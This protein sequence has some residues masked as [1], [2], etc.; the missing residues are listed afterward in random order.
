MK[1]NFNSAVV[2][3]LWQ[4]VSSKQFDPDDPETK[5][6]MMLLKSQIQDRYS[7]SMFFPTLFK[8]L[9]MREVDRKLQ[10]LKSKMKDIIEDHKL[11]IDYQNPRDFIDVYLGHMRENAGSSFN[12]EQ[13]VVVCLDLIEAGTETTSTTLVW[14]ILYMALYPEIQKR[15]QKEIEDKIGSRPPTIDDASRLPY[16][17]ATVMETQRVSIMAPASLPHY[18][19]KD[20]VVSGYNFPKGTFFIANLSRE[21][22]IDE[23]NYNCSQQSLFS[24]RILMDPEVFPNPK[25]FN[26]GR[27]MDQCGKLRRVEE[28]APFSVGR[29]IC[30]GESLAKNSLFLFF[31][32]VF[33]RTSIS[34]TQKRLNP[35]DSFVGVTRCPNPFEVKVNTR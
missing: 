12:D 13:L 31:V 1:D 26:P 11:D 14:S 21:V 4:I 32:R 30:M 9:P 33:Q 8:L 7:K 20:S 19:T 2:N 10:I 18:L 27:F 3:T 17:M 5:Q 6:I 15:C 24:T 22:E 28:F 25:D 35:D 23:S 34:Q 16:V 29:R